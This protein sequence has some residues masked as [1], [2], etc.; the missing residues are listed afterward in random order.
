MS[1]DSKKNVLLISSNM[2]IGGFQKALISLLQCFDYDR[3][4]VDLLLFSTR[5]VFLPLIPPQVNLLPPPISETYFLRAPQAAVQLLKEQKFVLAA[6]RLYSGLA[7]LF[8]KGISAKI[9]S[10]GIPPIPNKYDAAID[11]NGQHILYYLANKIN[12]ERKISF[13]HSDYKK[14][15]YYERIDRKEYQKVDAIATIS[16]LCV[17]SMCDIFPEYSHKIHCVENIIS[18]KT[19]NLFPIGSN[20]FRDDF[21]GFRFVTVGRVCKEKGVYLALECCSLLKKRGVHFRW[22]WVGPPDSA[23]NYRMLPAKYGIDDEFVFLGSTNNPYDYMRGADLIVH[24]SY[25]E[26]KSVAIEEAKVLGKPIVATNFSTVGNQLIDGE[27][28][29]IVPMDPVA[30][31]D[32]IERILDDQVL[33][34]KIEKNLAAFKNGNENE[35]QK[36]YHL[37]EGTPL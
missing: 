8:D 24:P 13:F 19:V 37:I 5:G 21:Q 36:L 2:D 23:A 11:F 25:F 12:A 10:Q 17:Q 32:A 18:E 16:D 35:I 22:Y 4:N 6:R 3:Y 31:A 28:G 34:Q 30:L 29:L 33:Y 14:W 26:G 9:I 20:D 7:S 27:T 1:A 15:P